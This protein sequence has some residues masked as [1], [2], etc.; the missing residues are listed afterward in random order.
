ML[1]SLTCA[2]LNRN[3]GE[4]RLNTNHK[5]ATLF[6]SF[7]PMADS[8]YKGCQQTSHKMVVFTGFLTL[9]QADKSF[10]SECLSTKEDNNPR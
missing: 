7:C 8:L 10:Q 5:S 3:A 1:T 9:K 6:I 4:D 2:K